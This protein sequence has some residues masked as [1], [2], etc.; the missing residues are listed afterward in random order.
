MPCISH[1]EFSSFLFTPTGLFISFPTHAGNPSV[2]YF[3]FHLFPPWQNAFG[4]HFLLLP[5]YFLLCPPPPP[6]KIMILITDYTQ[7]KFTRVT[8]KRRY[9]DTYYLLQS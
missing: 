3:F 2:C 7:I 1:K 5:L 6:R 9:M 8:T 4:I